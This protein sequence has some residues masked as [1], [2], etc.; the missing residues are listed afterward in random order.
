MSIKDRAGKN[1]SP[2]NDLFSAGFQDSA[3]IFVR[4]KVK[5]RNV[6]T[7]VRLPVFLDS[8]FHYDFSQRFEQ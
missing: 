5:P 4:K 3:F 6:A 1:P 2:K 8:L 7:E